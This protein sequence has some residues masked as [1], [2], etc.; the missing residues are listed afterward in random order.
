VSSNVAGVFKFPK[1]GAIYN[2]MDMRRLILLFPTFQHAATGKP[3][4]RCAHDLAA[5][6]VHEVCFATDNDG[7]KYLGAYKIMFKC[8][9]DLADLSHLSTAVSH[10]LDMR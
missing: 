6:Q 10:H 4:K 3:W 5:G 1:T 9:V 7:E 8:E 2:P